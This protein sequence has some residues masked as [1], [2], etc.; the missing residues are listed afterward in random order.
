MCRRTPAAV[1]SG[2]DFARGPPLHKL[3]IGRSKRFAEVL[4]EVPERFPLLVRT[5]RDGRGV[6][7]DC[8][9]PPP[10]RSPRIRVTDPH[11]TTGVSQLPQTAP[12]E[13]V[14]RLRLEA[15]NV[16]LY[17]FELL[18]SRGISEQERAEL[19]SR[20][21]FYP[22]TD[23]LHAP[24]PNAGLLRARSAKPAAAGSRHRST[25]CSRTTAI[26]DSGRSSLALFAE[27]ALAAFRARFW[28]TA[29]RVYE[30]ARK[31]GLLCRYFICSV[32]SELPNSTIPELELSRRVTGPSAS[33]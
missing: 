30:R 3:V 6:G 12:G 31:P 16:A 21:V 26:A 29:I 17:R 9:R 4:L 10:R 24:S 11:G 28:C 32:C 25:R 5:G 7:Q 23:E 13:Y 20:S 18:D 27:A 22:G 15:S 14:T 1:V 2:I 8:G 19:G 33:R